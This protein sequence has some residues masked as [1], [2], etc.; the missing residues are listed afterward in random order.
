MEVQPPSSKPVASWQAETSDICA[1]ARETSVSCR[2]APRDAPSSFPD[3]WQGT[4]S[5][6]RW[7]NA[8]Q[9]RRDS[10]SLVADPS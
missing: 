6:S 8:E 1:R 9:C 2:K 5:R 4:S 10:A 7:V 3:D